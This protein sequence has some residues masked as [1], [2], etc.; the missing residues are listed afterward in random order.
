M[1]SLSQR[2]RAWAALVTFTVTFGLGVMTLGHLGPEDDAACGP[3]GSVAGHPRAQFEAVKLAT[4]AAH[5][6]FCHWQRVVG[7]ASL[8]AIS[9]GFF[10]LQP[11]ARVV[12]PS[13]RAAGLDAI[14][15]RLSRGPPARLS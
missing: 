11:L 7:S 2:L 6:P 4:A 1:A 9:A 5:C 14:D 15:G 8:A 3:V 12:P 10:E 13:S